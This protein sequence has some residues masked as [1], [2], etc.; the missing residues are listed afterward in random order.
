[1]SNDKP[2]SSTESAE[3]VL[4]HCIRASIIAVGE[5]PTLKRLY[6]GKLDEISGLLQKRKEEQTKRNS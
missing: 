1:L 4:R 6:R 3:K 5:E 2:S